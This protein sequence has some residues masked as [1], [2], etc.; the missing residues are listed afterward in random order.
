VYIFMGHHGGL[1]DNPLLRSVV[2]ECGVSGAQ[3]NEAWF[4]SIVRCVSARFAQTPPSPR[5]LL[6]FS[7]NTEADHVL[8]ATDAM[9]FFAEQADKHGFRCGRDEQLGGDER[10]ELEELQSRRLAQ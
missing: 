2:P 6:F 5:V 4:V 8:F 9:R 7:L 10:R 3:V 1:F